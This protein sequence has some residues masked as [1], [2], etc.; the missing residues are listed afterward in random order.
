MFKRTMHS[1]KKLLHLCLPYLLQNCTRPV[2]L[3]NAGEKKTEQFLHENGIYSR[4]ICASV[5][6]SDQH[7]DR[8]TYDMQ[9]LHRNAHEWAN[10]MR[11]DAFNLE[12]NVLLNQVIQSAK[13]LCTPPCNRRIYFTQRALHHR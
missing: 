1:K 12:I 8:I 3:E 4:L 9:Q 10:G 6:L 13:N 11:R 7:M 2:A 5:P